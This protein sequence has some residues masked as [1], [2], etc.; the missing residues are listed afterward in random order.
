MKTS[1]GD[2]CVAA[3]LDYDTVKEVV[4]IYQVVAAIMSARS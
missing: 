1:L 2:D 4:Q 3:N